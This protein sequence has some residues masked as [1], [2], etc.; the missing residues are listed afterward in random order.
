MRFDHSVNSMSIMNRR[1]LTFWI[2]G[3][4]SLARACRAASDLEN[5]GQQ[6]H[7]KYG[8][9][10]LMPENEHSRLLNY[11]QLQQRHQLLNQNR[12]R[13]A[14]PVSVSFLVT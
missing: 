4:V 9:H 11:E 13:E 1:I 6:N 2:F 8:G 14:Q 7:Y 5:N 12:Q 10:Q 3:V